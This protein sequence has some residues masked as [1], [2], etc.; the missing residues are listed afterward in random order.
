MAD[1][2]KSFGHRSLW[3]FVL[4]NLVSLSAW[5]QTL[6]P[7]FRVNGYTPGNQYIS[8]VASGANGDSIAIW[9]DN[10]RGGYTFMQRF[11]VNGRPLQFGDWYI[12]YNIKGI[13]A[14]GRGNYVT[15]RSGFDGSGNGVFASVYSRAG[16]ILVYDFR[17][18]DS[19]T[20]DQDGPSVAM[21]AN[22]NFVIS[23]T[24]F[25]DSS[26][27]PAVYVKRFTSTGQPLGPQVRI[28]SS[29]YGPQYN[30][31]VGID[32]NGGFAATWYH[33]AWGTNVLDTWSR[34]YNAAG[35]PVTGQTRANSYT[36]DVQVGSD[37]AMADDGSYVVVWESYGQDGDQWGVFGQRFNALGGRVGTEFQVNTLTAG[38]QQLAKV[39]MTGSGKFVVVFLNDN[40]INDPAMILTIFA[41][42]YGA[43]GQALA[44]EFPVSDPSIGKAYWSHVGID[45]NDNY[46]VGWQHYDLT[47]GDPDI[48]ARRYRMDSPIPALANGIP[49]NNLSGTIGSWQYFK[50]IVPA[51]QNLLD[52]QMTG[53]ALGDADLYVR[54]GNPPSG[55]TWDYRP[56]LV[57]NNERVG[58]A[59][60][61][62][63]EWYIGIN[64]YENFDNVS[65][66]ATYQ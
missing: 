13:A 58:V 57:G 17:V 11:D 12:G 3:L 51:G 62:S 64:G 31:G 49:V 48:Y 60:P 8:D 39:A 14:D 46:F 43:D 54:N 10:A 63:G 29:T 24:N 41:R 50:I 7:P 32:A 28:S 38:S 4:I 47:T 2:C 15:V 34:R 19:T 59:N 22:G 65:I 61:A 55:A 26:G 42:E 21:N 25:A 56:Y 6:S 27:K 52:I 44:V 37:I 45:N 30:M 9:K 5:A 33:W 36:P 35:L 53:P 16:S 20:G 66:S 23:W 18:N 1:I 40:R